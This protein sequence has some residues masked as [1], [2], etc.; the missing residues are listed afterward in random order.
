MEND[1][2]IERR[3]TR[4]LA[5]QRRFDAANN[6]SVRDAHLPKTRRELLEDVALSAIFLGIVAV[7]THGTFK[8]SPEPV[9]RSSSDRFIP[10]VD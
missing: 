2:A 5:T 4:E 3:R 7:A 8:D 9:D 6:S 10:L 1:R